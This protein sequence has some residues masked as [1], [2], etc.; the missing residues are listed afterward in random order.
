MFDNIRDLQSP[1]EALAHEISAI[2]VSV[3]G[4]R[5]LQDLSVQEAC[6]LTATMYFA[7]PQTFELKETWGRIWTDEVRPILRFG[8]TETMGDMKY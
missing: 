1:L 6:E 8:A 4:I 7:G 5:Y 3:S 2:T